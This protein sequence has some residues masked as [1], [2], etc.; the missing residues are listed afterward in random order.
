MLDKINFVYEEKIF[1]KRLLDQ[2]VIDQIIKLEDGV[3]LTK[4]V[5]L[6]LL[7]KPTPLNF[8]ERS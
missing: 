5:I 4:E 8:N 2:N 6:S 1:G 7:E 3:L